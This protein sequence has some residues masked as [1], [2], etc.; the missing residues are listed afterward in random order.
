M[1]QILVSQKLYVTPELKRKKK[2]YKLEFLLSIFVF[3]LLIS[4]Y[5]YA[6]YDKNKSEET[7]KI[8]L[9]SATELQEIANNEKK[10][11]EEAYNVWVFVLEDT[12]GTIEEVQ[13]NQDTV[14]IHDE[15][16]IIEQE[17]YYDSEGEPYTVIATVT[18]HKLDVEYA[19]LSRTSDELLKINPTKFEGYEK[20]PDPN[21]VGNFCIV[22]H[23]YRD[24]RFF[25]KVP[26]L[27][28]GDT[29]SLTDNY[30]RTITYVMYDKY[31]VDPT[32]ISCLDQNTN[33]RK[34][35]TLITCNYDGSQRV[36]T[37]FREQK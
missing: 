7:G 12:N 8:M 37:K 32:D 16:K 29:I 21:E 27:E 25:G 4:F 9:S 2:F 18:I 13:K 5:I 6:E 3:C 35:V 14:E 31:E 30:G 34:E 24:S 28:L 17:T 20:G 33:G 1:N 19:V 15:Q 10:L 23:N 36:I 26:T 22:G 11:N